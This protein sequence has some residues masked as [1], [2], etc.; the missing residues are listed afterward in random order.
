MRQHL[1][2]ILLVTGLCLVTFA[3]RSQDKTSSEPSVPPELISIIYPP[4][5]GTVM[6]QA[7]ESFHSRGEHLPNGASLRFESL[8]ETSIQAAQR[9]ARGDLKSVMWI[10]P[11]P[12]LAEY[13]N[14]NLVNLG[15]RQVDCKKIFSTSLTLATHAAVTT[16]VFES[17]ARP[18]R[19]DLFEGSP[20]RI[21]GIPRAS[22]SDAGILAMLYLTRQQRDVATPGDQQILGLRTFGNPDQLLEGLPVSYFGTTR[23]ALT[24]EQ[25]IIRHN[26][27]TNDPAKLIQATYLGDNPPEL[28]YTACISE[29]DWLSAAQRAGALLVQKHLIS[30]DP[31]IAA[32]K[33]G[34][35]AVQYDTDKLGS[36][37]PQTGT[38]EVV[39][40]KTESITGPLVE[41]LLKHPLLLN[42]KVATMY[43]LDTSASM[44]G[45]PLTGI[46]R[47]VRTLIEKDAKDNPAGVIAFNANA[48]LVSAPTLDRM[49]LFP[50]IAGLETD[51]GSA[52]YDAILLAA[53]ELSKQEYSTMQRRIVLVTDGNDQSSRTVLNFFGSAFER[54]AAGR[55]MALNIFLLRREGIDISDLTQIVSI[56]GGR[57]QEYSATQTPEEIT[58][59]I[60]QN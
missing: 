29:A 28:E 32:Q 25:T 35:R 15:A 12:A 43:V 24:T 45:N 41:N 44:E 60:N 13:V 40:V 27:S 48:T 53:D 56:L 42:P 11:M 6:T 47:L 9:I 57:M 59:I 39:P 4:E 20:G 8:E 19:A 3:C 17:S 22:Q 52:L 1:G 38:E 7:L 16:K 18:V 34:F 5:I 30:Q 55:E 33:E 26:R 58:R 54:R 51:G 37:S 31:Q 14:N 10:T 23:V 21:A 2:K 50:Y 46:K 49:G 36:F